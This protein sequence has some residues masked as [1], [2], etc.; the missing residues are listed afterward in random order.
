MTK[1]LTPK[2]VKELAELALLAPLAS[3]FGF[4]LVDWDTYEV[5]RRDYIEKYGDA[6]HAP[7]RQN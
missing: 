7:S 2:Q 3:K 6:G 4:A 5:M 1:T